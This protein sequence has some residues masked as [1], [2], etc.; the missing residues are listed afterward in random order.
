MSVTF[1]LA[2]SAYCLVGIIVVFRAMKRLNSPSAR[3]GMT[4]NAFIAARTLCIVAIVCGIG[5]MFF[6][7]HYAVTL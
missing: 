1:A 4:N 2:M 7:L 6:F 3:E 5:L